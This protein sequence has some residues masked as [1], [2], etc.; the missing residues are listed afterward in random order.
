M[1]APAPF[2]FLAL[3]LAA[4]ALPA[5]QT[6]RGQINVKGEVQ[7][8]ARP[9]SVSLVFTGRLRGSRDGRPAN[10]SGG[11]LFRSANDKAIDETHTGRMTTMLRTA[12]LP[13]GERGRLIRR[14]SNA[15]V[16]VTSRVISWPGGRVTLNRPLNPSKSE[17]QQFRGR[18]TL[19]FRA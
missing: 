9:G 16:R 13:T 11:G 6:Y 17:L 4:P 7:S 15:R 19:R 10:V 14:I 5:A 12:N 3:I 2:L 18:G 8:E 1:K